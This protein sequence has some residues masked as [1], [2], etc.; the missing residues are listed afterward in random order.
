M[1]I[2][3]VALTTGLPAKTI[4]Y[5]ESVRLIPT[6]LRRPNG[7]RSCDALVVDVTEVDAPPGVETLHWRLMTTHDV[8]TVDEAKEIVR[9]YRLRWTIEQVFRTVKSAA[10]QAD[11]SQVTEA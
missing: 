4:R 2:G 9:W 5:Y 8:T 1:N 7:Y 3:Q 6:A 11:Q 10:M